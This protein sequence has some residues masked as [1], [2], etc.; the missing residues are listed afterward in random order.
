M[1][2]RQIFYLV[3]PIVSFWVFAYPLGR[4]SHWLTEGSGLGLLYTV[5]LWVFST[6]AMWYSFNGPKMLVRYIMVHWMGVSFVFMSLTLVAELPLL[7]WGQMAKQVAIVV[8]V[9]GTFLAVGALIAS[10]FFKVKTITLRSKRLT[11]PI[12]L[13]QLSDVHIG[14]RQAKFMRRAV[15]KLNAEQP[16]IV[17]ITGDLIDSSA[18]NAVD[19]QALNDINVPTFF[20][21]G[22]HE[23]HADLKKVLKIVRGLGIT[24][25]RQQSTV[26]DEIQLVGIDDADQ[27]NQVEQML[28]AIDLQSGLFNVLLYHR[29]VGWAAARQGTIDLM[30]SGHTHNGQI[31]PFNWIVK[32]QFDRIAGLYTKEDAWLYVNSGTGTWG[33]LMRLGTSNEITIIDLLPE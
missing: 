27:R 9:L 8:V 26:I 29:P 1:S 20:V 17:V 4:L 28:P 16:D 31:F 10:H 18:V 33:P 11:R 2:T 19:L 25:L 23:R 3:F 30:L 32:Q 13:A 22:N 24:T 15:D 5:L 6:M 12:K 21:I 14:S 7:F